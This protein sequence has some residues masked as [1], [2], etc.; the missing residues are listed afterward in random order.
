VWQRWL[1]DHDLQPEIDHVVDI[2]DVI[3]SEEADG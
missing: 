3:A 2:D 1:E